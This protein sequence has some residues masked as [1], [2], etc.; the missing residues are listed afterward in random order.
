[1]CMNR[2]ILPTE[3]IM[4]TTSTS[5]EKTFVAAREN[6]AKIEIKAKEQ[7]FN[8]FCKKISDRA[9]S[10]CLTRER[11]VDSLRGFQIRHYACNEARD[12]FLSGSQINCKKAAVINAYDKI[13][14]ERSRI[15]LGISQQSLSSDNFIE[16]LFCKEN[17][18]KVA[19]EIAESLKHEE[20]AWQDIAN[21]LDVVNH[22]QQLPPPPPN[23]QPALA[24]ANFGTYT[25][26]DDHATVESYFKNSLVSSHVFIGKIDGIGSVEYIDKNGNHIRYQATDKK[27]ELL[28]LVNGE[29]QRVVTSLKYDPA[30]CTVT[31]QTGSGEIPKTGDQA[32]RQL[33]AL[34]YKQKVIC[35][36]PLRQYIGVNLRDCPVQVYYYFA[37]NVP[38]RIQTIVEQAI[39]ILRVDIPAIVW[40]ARSGGEESARLQI[41]A[42]NNGCWS[43]LGF[44][45]QGNI[46]NFD[47]NWTSIPLGTVLHEFLH[48][49]GLGHEHQ[50]TD[51]H[52]Y[53]DVDLQAA[54]QAYKWS[55]EKILVNFEANSDFH[56]FRYDF[57]SITHY[58]SGE[59]IQPT[60]AVWCKVGERHCLSPL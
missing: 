21:F 53:I 5:L 49:L 45:A 34:T 22:I 7:E 23:D 11:I 24:T 59:G 16:V 20:I 36:P 57:S 10:I 51:R 48:T 28:K 39:S 50:R 13:E 26:Y 8:A 54:Q 25:L 47:P 19:E 37:N 56:P 40:K 27:Q 31:D 33:H 58:P 30:T 46:I 42:A 41:T 17:D 55:A 9:T 35:E 3:F 4:Q 12:R 15:E 43:H 6:K 14:R 32:V 60:R 38:Q 29:V 44:R 52:E 1:M 18:I 2:K